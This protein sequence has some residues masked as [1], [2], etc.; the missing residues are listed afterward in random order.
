MTKKSNQIKLKDKTMKRKKDDIKQSKLK[1]LFNTFSDK[2]IF[3][4]PIC[5]KIT[6]SITAGILL[7]QIVY[8]GQNYSE[9]YKTDKSFCEELSMGLYELKGAKFKLKQMGIIKIQRKGMPAKTHYKININN[10][11][12]YITKHKESQKLKRND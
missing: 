11:I 5:A 8:W 12:Q 6:D 3:Y 9:F 2:P 7:S 10:L 4:Y 1:H